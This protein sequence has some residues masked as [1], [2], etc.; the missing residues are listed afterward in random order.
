MCE[1]FKFSPHTLKSEWFINSVSLS[2]L[3]TYSR[4]CTCS[5]PELLSAYLVQ[6]F[7]GEE[8]LEKCCSWYNACL[9]QPSAL[10]F[11]LISFVFDVLPF[12]QVD[13]LPPSLLSLQRYPVKDKVVTSQLPAVVQ[14]ITKMT[15]IIIKWEMPEIHSSVSVIWMTI[16]SPFG[17]V[18]WCWSTFLVLHFSSLFFPL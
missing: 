15:V 9:I 18:G 16:W 6:K 7:Q 3:H 4:A 2:F 8:W 1:L 14:A 11:Y 12:V 5:N 17:R 13:H 10:F